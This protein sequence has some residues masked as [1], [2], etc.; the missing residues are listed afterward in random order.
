[1]DQQEITRTVEGLHHY[2]IDVWDWDAL[3]E[4]VKEYVGTV[5]DIDQG[6]RGEL[7]AKRWITTKATDHLAAKYAVA[8]A[9]VDRVTDLL[10]KEPDTIGNALLDH[11]YSDLFTLRYASDCERQW[12]IRQ[13]FD[14]SLGIQDDPTDEELEEYRNRPPE[15][16]WEEEFPDHDRPWVFIAKHLA[17]FANKVAERIG[18]RMRNLDPAP[19]GPELNRIE[20]RCSTAVYV[21][22][23]KELLKKGYIVMPGMNGKEGEGNI[24]ELFRRL[25]QAFILTNKKGDISTQ[26][27]QRRYDGRALARSKAARLNFPE[28]KEI[29]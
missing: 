8:I 4:I 27:L 5:I 20:W 13:V 6:H 9:E 14:P 18:E 15:P 22:I 19:T 28:A 10:R 11:V 29:K 26:E 23:V 25:S 16:V 2:V 24:T 1:M 21:H 12:S 7:A 17:P 3:Q